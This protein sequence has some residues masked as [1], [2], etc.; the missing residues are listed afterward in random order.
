MRGSKLDKEILQLWTGE[1][2]S[3]E[4]A[5]SIIV[6][7]FEE[8]EKRTAWRRLSILRLQ[9]KLERIEKGHGQVVYKLSEEYKKTK[10]Q[11]GLIGNYIIEALGKSIAESKE[12][13]EHIYNQVWRE[14]DSKTHYNDEDNDEAF[15]TAINN[16]LN[17][18]ISKK[19]MK[20]FYKQYDALVKACLQPLTDPTVFARLVKDEEL[21]DIL[22][23]QINNLVREFMTMWDFLYKHPRTVSE[24]T[25]IL[26][27][28]DARRLKAKMQIQHPEIE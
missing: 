7:K 27:Q 23:N 4:F 21:P 22:Q 5:A 19:E 20:T 14:I 26:E 3:E 16:I 25:R 9:G 18:K 12:M 11:F 24:L 10:G 13:T 28:E 2:E 8:N 1:N 6:N 17:R 15:V